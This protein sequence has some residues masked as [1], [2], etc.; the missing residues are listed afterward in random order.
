M[1]KAAD[2][3][4][5]LACEGLCKEYS[6]GAQTLQILENVALSV[7]VGEMVAV[8]GVSG[9]GKT[10]LLHLLGGLDVPTAGEVWIAGMALSTL[11]EKSRG[12][13]RNHSLG[14][15]YQFHHLLEE[16]NVLENVAMPLL[17]RGARRKEIDTRVMAILERIGLA[18]RSV[19]RPSQLSGGERQRVAIA[20]ALVT[21]PQCVLLDEPTGNLDHHNAT[22]FQELLGELN[23]ELGIACVVATHSESLAQVAHRLL[24]L[25]SGVLQPA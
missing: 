11:S 20:R 10:T 18:D 12:H 1:N 23:R 14:F 24:H 2:A 6:Q 9:S 5:V 25:E 3:A 4:P 15:V 19:H 22:L 7:A 13:L 8:M 16:F 17:I 21:E